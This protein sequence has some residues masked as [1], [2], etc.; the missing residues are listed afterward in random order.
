[1]ALGRPEVDKMQVR[2][3]FF[4][5]NGDFTLWHHGT[6]AGLKNNFHIGGGMGYPAW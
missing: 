6:T 3:E 5:K 1:V 2:R 4:T